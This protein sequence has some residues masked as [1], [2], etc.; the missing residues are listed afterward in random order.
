M[1]ED[2]KVTDGVWKFVGN[3][4][5]ICVCLSGKGCIQ[6]PERGYNGAYPFVNEDS[7]KT[8]GKICTRVWK[9]FPK[10]EC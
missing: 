9:F 5:L 2:I 1:H 8:S 4:S 10:E 7:T 6:F 3:P